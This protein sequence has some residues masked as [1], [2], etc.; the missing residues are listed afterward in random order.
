MKDKK[1]FSCL[2]TETPLD[3]D[4]CFELFESY[5]PF[6]ILVLIGLDEACMHIAQ[7]THCP[8]KVE[9][10]LAFYIGVWAD[11]SVSD[12]LYHFVIV[13]SRLL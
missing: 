7:C 1:D 3:V 12:K 4:T 11:I 10:L 5:N 8:L 2:C 6:L 13:T 9:K